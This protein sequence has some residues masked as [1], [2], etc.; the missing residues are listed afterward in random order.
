MPVCSERLFPGERIISNAEIPLHR[1]P[2]P[3]GYR[4][5][6]DEEIPK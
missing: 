6:E 1:A 4:A 3:L 5:L 2:F